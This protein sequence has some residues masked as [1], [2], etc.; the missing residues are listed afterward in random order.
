MK[1][2]A[3]IFLSVVFTGVK[4][5]CLAV[6]APS[7]ALHAGLPF[8]DTSAVGPANFTPVKP[9]DFRATFGAEAIRS[10]LRILQV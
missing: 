4:T 5:Q 7:L 1:G 6:R 2:R 8:K 10:S 9:Q 3:V